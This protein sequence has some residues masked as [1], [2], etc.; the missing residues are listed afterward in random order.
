MTSLAFETLLWAGAIGFGL[1]AGVYAAFSGFIMASLAALAPAEGMRAMQSINRVIV[2]SPFMLLFF[3][4]SAAAVVLAIMGLLGRGGPA[5]LPAA[6]AGVL[7]ALGMFGVTAAFNVP[8]NNRLE[9]TPADSAAA[10]TVWDSY[11]REWTRWNTLRTAA[12]TA[13]AALSVYALRLV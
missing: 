2:R 3:A 11:V 5:A 13:A 4:T 9:A 8:R 10:A 7:Y 6:I 1:M 12:S